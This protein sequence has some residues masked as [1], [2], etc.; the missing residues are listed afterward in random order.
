VI[1]LE[2]PACEDVADKVAAEDI[3]A[4]S[5]DVPT[6]DKPD[7]MLQWFAELA[8]SGIGD[9]ARQVE[10][11]VCIGNSSED[12]DLDSF[13][14]L[15]LK[16][17]ETNTVGLCCRPLAP[18]ITNDEQTVSP[19]N[20]LTKP[21]RGQQRKRRQKRDFEKD[22]LPSISSLRR[23]EIIDGIQLLEGLVQ[24]TGGFWES[25]LTRRRRARGKNPKK[26]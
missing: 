12:D 1:D 2:V 7:N 3:L 15:T 26:G 11:Q 9:Q 25:S 10:V 13:E 21:K 19:L 16:L 8:V 6:T 22:I 23:P 14:S 5:M 18:A 24:T 20:L 4:L 17:E